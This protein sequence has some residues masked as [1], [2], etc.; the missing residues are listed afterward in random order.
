MSPANTGAKR[1]SAVHLEVKGRLPLMG[2]AQVEQLLYVL[3]G[4]GRLENVAARQRWPLTAGSYAWIPA[5]ARLELKGDLSALQIFLPPGLEREYSPGRSPVSGSRVRWPVVGQAR[6]Q[7]ALRAPRGAPRFTPLMHPARQSHGR[8]YLGLVDAPAGSA[9]PLNT[10]RDAAELI[11]I[12]AGGGQ[13]ACGEVSTA[14]GSGDALYLPQGVPHRMTIN[15]RI[16]ALQLYLPAGPE[17]RFL[18]PK[19]RK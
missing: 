19:K 3:R 2:K 6:G 1:A 12:L 11:F 5:D 17:Q 7:R 4:K 18:K 14:V 16:R 15:R 8:F 13:A 9:V 10:H